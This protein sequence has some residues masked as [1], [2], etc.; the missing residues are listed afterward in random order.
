[1]IPDSESDSESIKE[2][3][4]KGEAKKKVSLP[5]ARTMKTIK[6]R[7]R[8]HAVPIGQKPCQHHRGKG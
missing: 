8:N 2:T 4:P 6:K 1:M 7:L 3:S 5:N